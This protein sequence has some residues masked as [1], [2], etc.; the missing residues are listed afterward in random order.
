MR[1][2]KTYLRFILVILVAI[3]ISSCI[4]GLPLQN[5]HLTDRFYLGAPDVKEQMSI[6]YQYKDELYFG[7]VDQT[8]FAV[9]YNDDFIIAKRHPSTW[10]LE[11]NRDITEYYLIDVRAVKAERAVYE[12]Q[13]SSFHR[14][15]TDEQGHKVLGP[16][17]TSTILYSPD[18][19]QPLTLEQFV[20]LRRQLRVPEALDFTIIY[21]SM[22]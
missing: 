1:H 14:V 5:K 18:A 6:S 17:T 8:V 7:I 11:I 21:D 9:G 20:K 4:W 3:Q 15:E 2:Y 16:K 13:T 19:A 12:E 22:K 10:D